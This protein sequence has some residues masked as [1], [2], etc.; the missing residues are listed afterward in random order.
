MYDL[1]DV[2]LAATAGLVSASAFLIAR[3]RD[4]EGTIAEER[5][6]RLDAEE[7]LITVNIKRENIETELQA[8]LEESRKEAAEQRR[9]ADDAKRVAEIARK[10]ASVELREGAMRVVEETRE[11]VRR[12]ASETEQKLV[13]REERLQ[14]REAVVAEKE[15]LA[16]QRDLAL[17]RRE[18]SIEAERAKT[19]ELHERAVKLVDDRQARLQAAA[20]MSGEEA[21]RNMMDELLDGV[22]RDSAREAK[23]IEDIA[24]Q[25]AEKKAKRII[26]LAIQRYAGEHV[27]ERATTS[28]HL[29]HDDMKGRIIGKEG[30]NIRA[31]QETLGVDLIIDDTPETIVVSAFDPVRREVARMAIEML[32]EDGRIHPSRIE[33][34]AILAQER[35]DS[36]VTQ[37][38]EAALMELG[39]TR[40]HHELSRLVGQ[41][42]YRYS[43]AQNVLLH[44]IECG[45]LAGAMAA[46]LGQNEKTARRA[47]LL[48]DIGK[49]VSHEQEGGHAMVGA[50][51]ARKH[52]EDPVIVNAIAA[53]HEDEQPSSVIASLVM[54][55]DALS[56]ARPGARREMLD[57]YVKRLRDLEE[58]STRFTG[59]TRA[60]A[61]Q[62]G[63]EVRVIVEPSE[64]SDVEAALLAREISKRIEEELNYP[65]QIR[66]TVVRETRAV[67]YAK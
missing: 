22:R 10:E 31:L 18:A 4:H 47:G 49:A 63:R 20:G 44:S 3:L 54:A 59:V 25:E 58:I 55:A 50:A 2:V 17:S 5:R 45:F 56:G 33:E 6:K 23:E 28:I 42:K 32:L 12:E 62:A 66:V 29:A 8:K 46:E 48:H 37:A 27:Q 60:F 38:A 1:N 30:R 52:G 16:A 40:M 34:V 39:V 57:G 7:T 65:G 64:V 43:Y 36:T 26:G 21:R 51:Y 24:R 14:K 19:G 61:I 53:H 9:L 41:L 13:K 35:V 15:E 67:D 11:E